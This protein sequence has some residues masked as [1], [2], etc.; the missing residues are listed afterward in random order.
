M[1]TII[2]LWPHEDNCCVCDK[3]VIG[4]HFGIPMYESEWGRS[5]YKGEWAGFTACDSCYDKWLEWDALT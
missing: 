4:P 1:I 2:N 5:D 3:I